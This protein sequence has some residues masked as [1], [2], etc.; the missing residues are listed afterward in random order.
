MKHYFAKQG[1]TVL[2]LDDLT[3]DVNDKTVTA[4]RTG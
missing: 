1:A 3:T 2:M 4:S